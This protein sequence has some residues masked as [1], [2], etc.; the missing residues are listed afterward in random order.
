MIAIL[1]IK[2]LHHIYFVNK[3]YSNLPNYNKW[4]KQLKFRFI[5][6]KE[7]KHQLILFL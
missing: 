2:T 5:Q 1:T 3:I 6:I 7:N 4:N